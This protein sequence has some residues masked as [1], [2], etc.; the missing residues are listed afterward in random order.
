MN[1]AD[2][3]QIFTTLQQL[4]SRV[5]QLESQKT[6]SASAAL[7]P[8]KPLKISLEKFVEIY[9]DVP[10]I[11]EEYAT[12]VSL[13]ADSYRGKNLNQIVVETSPSGNYWIL[14]LENSREKQYLLV[15][16]P[17][18]RI[19]VADNKHSINFLFD[20]PSGFKTAGSGNLYLDKPAIVKMLPGGNQWLL[21]NK[22][23]LATYLPANN[24]KSA[25]R[26]PSVDSQNRNQWREDLK[27]FRE[28]FEREINNKIVLLD[29]KLLSL[30]KEWIKKQE[31]PKDKAKDYEAKI[32]HWQEYPPPL[33]QQDSESLAHCKDRKYHE[34]LESLKT[35]IESLMEDLK[36]TRDEVESRQLLLEKITKY[37][38]SKIAN[39][40]HLYEM[41][42]GGVAENNGREMGWTIDD[43]VEEIMSPFVTRK[44]HIKTE[45]KVLD[46]SQEEQELLDLY[47]QN[48]RLLSRVSYLLVD[49]VTRG[50]ETDDGKAFFKSNI[51][52]DFCITV[53]IR[54]YYV[55]PNR[56][57][58][59]S[60]GILEAAIYTGLFQALS[61]I[62]DVILGED[63][64][65]IKPAK[66]ERITNEEWKIIEA[67]K[68]DFS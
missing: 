2:L 52:G 22:G 63:I 14:L 12:P 64:K 31:L 28:E 66:L 21:Q 54:N 37:C 33:K 20:L 29:K 40:E 60:K 8:P 11:F 7:S 48:Y 61:P 35:K 50:G 24:D 18:R 53:G 58:I 42:K 55:F 23:I 44:N 26:I 51:T 62:P 10:T 65:V 56:L 57:K 15:L 27:S 19:R 47:N 34:E 6:I 38:L 43:S 17:L 3:S 13:T 16:N 46:Y 25:T 36:N 41:E 39:I 59:F 1:E 67:G 5:R 4:E 68:I 49:I 30:Q 32:N 9:N 45:G